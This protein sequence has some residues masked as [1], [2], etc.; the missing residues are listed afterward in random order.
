MCVCAYTYTYSR[1]WIVARVGSV[2]LNGP[3]RQPLLLGSTW[4]CHTRRMLYIAQAQAAFACVG[5][6]RLPLCVCVCVC[7]SLCV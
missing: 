6:N 7:V 2:K 5:V 1:I 4:A 3:L